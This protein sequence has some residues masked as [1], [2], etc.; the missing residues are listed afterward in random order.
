MVRDLLQPPLQVGDLAPDGSP[1]GLEL[2][3]AGPAQPDA[4]ADAR[5]VRPHPRESREQ[6]L[7][8]RQ[9]HLH[10]RLGRARPR[11]EDVEDHLGAIHHPHRE[12]FLQ[13]RPLERREGLVEQQ[14]RRARLL[15]DPLE[16]VHLPLP[17]VERGAGSFH[18]L[19]GPAH[20]LGAR[21]VGEPAELVEMVVHLGHVHG[22]LARGADQERALDGLLDVD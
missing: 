17:E 16:L 2:G 10:L 22:A 7:E 11:R 9:L 13:A 14:Q 19:V 20:Y 18:T 21:R 8:L 1:V 4:A 15:E 3:L 6:V 5:E 12:R